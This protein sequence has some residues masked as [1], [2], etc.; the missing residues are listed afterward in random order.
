M[1]RKV[2]KTDNTKNRKRKGKFLPKNEEVSEW[3]AHI[4]TWKLS[5]NI[6]IITNVF[7]DQKIVNVCE[8]T[9]GTIFTVCSQTFTLF[10]LGKA[11]V[12]VKI[13]QLSFR[14]FVCAFSLE[15]S[16]FLVRVFPFFVL[17]QTIVRLIL[18]LFL[19]KVCLYWDLSPGTLAFNANI[20]LLHHA[21]LNTEWE[22]D[23]NLSWYLNLDDA[24]LA[25][26]ARDPG[27]KSIEIIIVNSIIQVGTSLLID[28]SSI[29]I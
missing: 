6:S 3:K 28:L 24:V 14:V 5:W 19:Q 25:N 9:V 13:F 15:I 21:E 27:F 4:N 18:L 29:Y 17:L 23:F 11:S 22:R 26:K 16:S 10:W 20:Q 2:P 8:H 1:E 12:I 7:L